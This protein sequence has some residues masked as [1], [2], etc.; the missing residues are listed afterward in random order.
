MYAGIV[1]N[2]LFIGNAATNTTVNQGCGGALAFG[3]APTTNFVFNCT[4][5]NNWA[6]GG[7][8]ATYGGGALVKSAA[9]AH[10]LVQNCLFVG[11]YS[12]GYGGVADAAGGCGGNSL[13][14]NCGF[15]GNESVR[16][17]GALSLRGNSTAAYSNVLD[18]CTFAGNRCNSTNV[19]AAINIGL[20]TINNYITNCI[21]YSNGVVST[22]ST[23]D[24]YMAQSTNYFQN[25]CLSTTN[26]FG[27]LA[28][29]SGCITTYPQFVNPG[30]VSSGY[31][32]GT[33]LLSGSFN[34]RLQKT[35]LCRNNGVY[36]P[37]WMVGATDCSGYTP[38]GNSVIGTPRTLGSSVDIG[39]YE[40]IA[41]PASGTTVFFR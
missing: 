18:S 20:G 34:F 15:F 12:L 4:F 39:C 35:S 10:S 3:N 9:A 23:Q 40:Y 17:G 1:S 8:T 22:V 25:C 28:V 13:Y 2:C 19:G 36:E 16:G 29:F 21:F 38:V 32:Y 11:N 24:V 6:S 31:P 27:S 26:N 33:N 30:A 7:A 41:P 5:S 37:S 14:R